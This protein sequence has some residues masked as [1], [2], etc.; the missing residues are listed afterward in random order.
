MADSAL[1]LFDYWRSSASYRVRIAL[2]LKGLA[3]KQHPVH[4]VRDGGEQHASS[5]RDLNPQGL[6]PALVHNGQVLTQSLSIC[7]YLDEQFPEYALLPPDPLSRARARALAQTVACD[8][9]PLNNL[10]VQQQIRQRFSPGKGEVVEWMNHWVSEGFSAIEQWL[11]RSSAMGDFCMGDA[12]GLADCFLVPQVYNAERFGCDLA[13][14]PR[15]IEVTG[16][17]RGIPAFAAAA[18]E[19]QPDAPVE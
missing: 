19:A 9:H 3:F 16:R 10:R 12:P 4:L 13:P 15:I 8:I 14:F 6:V 17:C 18:P 2:H 11:S 5:Y 1:V 7:E